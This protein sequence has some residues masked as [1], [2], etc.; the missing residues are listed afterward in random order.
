MGKH[1]KSDSL[2]ALEGQLSV[3]KLR[4]LIRHKE[5]YHLAIYSLPEPAGL[6]KLEPSASGR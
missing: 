5:F 2:Q 3:L 1:Y 6:A 4:W